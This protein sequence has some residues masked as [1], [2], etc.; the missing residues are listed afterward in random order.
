M[1][2]VIDLNRDCYANL[3]ETGDMLTKEFGL[4][5]DK[6]E[7]EMCRCLAQLIGTRAARLSACGIAAICKKKKWDTCRVGADGSVF[8]KYP[9]FKERCAT[10]LREIL[11]WKTEEDPIQLKSAEDGSGVGAAL[12]AA[13]TIK[14]VEKG[15]YFGIKNLTGIQET[16]QAL[17]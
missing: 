4:A 14:R 16:I 12:I 3:H 9:H 7:L 1:R 15:T 2:A 17:A 10:A 5:A 11:D 13:L 6:H 8:A